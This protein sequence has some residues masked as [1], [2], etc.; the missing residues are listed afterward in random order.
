M[1]KVWTIIKQKSNSF[2]YR[3]YC[4]YPNDLIDHYIAISSLQQNFNPELGFLQRENYKAFNW[5][6]DFL[7]RWFKKYGVQQMLISG[8]GIYHI[9]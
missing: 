5:H 4:D 2:A 7:P 6:L 1:L 8:C 9:T 3:V